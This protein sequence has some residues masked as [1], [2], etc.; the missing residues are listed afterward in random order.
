MTMMMMMTNGN[1]E[2]GAE[3]VYISLMN[4]F[5]IYPLVILHIYIYIYKVKFSRYRPG[6]AQRVGRGIALLF[7]DRGTRRGWVV[8]VTPRP[9]FTPGK[10]PYPFYKK[11]GGPQ[12]RSGSAEN[13]FPTG[14]RS[15]TVQLVVS[16]YTDWATGSTHTHTHTHTHAYIYIYI[17]IGD[18]HL[19]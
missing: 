13:L 6:M 4:F 3:F 9:L 15:R 2:M 14:I 18:I 5:L 10:T 19:K 12:G 8:S 17:Y 1:L 16:R 11:L 7:H